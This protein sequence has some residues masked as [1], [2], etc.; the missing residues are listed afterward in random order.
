MPFMTTITVKLSP[1]TAAKLNAVAARKGVT[2]SQYIREALE[3]ALKKE[4][5]KPSLYD[6]MKDGLGCFDSGITDK[7]T[8]PKYMKGYGKP[9]NPH[10]HRTSLRAA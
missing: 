8:N 7:S 2:K 10:R 9:R 3:A 1:E 5:T 4:K 6:L